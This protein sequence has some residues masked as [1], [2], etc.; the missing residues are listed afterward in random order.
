MKNRIVALAAVVATVALLAVAAAPPE[1]TAELPSRQVCKAQKNPRA[2]LREQERAARCVIDHVRASA[3]VGRL[4]TNR[5]LQRAAGHKAQDLARC[6]F[7]HD[8]CGRPPDAW[9][10]HFGY[11]SGDWSW[12][13]NLATGPRR[14]TARRA[15]KSWLSSAPH[16][17]TL[18]QRSYEHIG[19]G[20][21]R[22]GGSA[23]W[24][25]E[26]GCHGC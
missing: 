6:G 18:L 7:T 21:K 20:F 1:A 17:E 26:V 25:L 8:A 12:G 3:G 2:G 13:E 23:F 15:V 22:D 16:R 5:A 9:A 14:M 10:K 19:V 24:V 11:D 4:S